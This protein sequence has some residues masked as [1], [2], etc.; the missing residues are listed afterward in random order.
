MFFLLIVITFLVVFC[1]L[2]YIC[3]TTKIVKTYRTR[4]KHRKLVNNVG[5]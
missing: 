5:L 1:F 2:A 4:V 3:V